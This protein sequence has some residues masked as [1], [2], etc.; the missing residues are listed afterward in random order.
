MGMADFYLRIT[1]IEDNEQDIKLI[2][3]KLTSNNSFSTIIETDNK[4]STISIEGKFDNMLP[5]LVLI[6]EIFREYKSDKIIVET[7]GVKEKFNF[8]N[9]E[10]F[11]YYVVKANKNKLNS[12]YKEL[13]YFSIDSKRYYKT[14]SRLRKYYKKIT[15]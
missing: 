8:E 6:F 1:F 5:T 2:F 13:G 15:K 10:D 14:R 9:I 7:Y 4:L 3:E 11:V 12:Y